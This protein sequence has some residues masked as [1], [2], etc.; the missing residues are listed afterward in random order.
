MGV[1]SSGML[2]LPVHAI[3]AGL[4]FFL[5]FAAIKQ[6]ARLFLGGFWIFILCFNSLERAFVCRPRYL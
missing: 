5:E 1:I 3:V 4:F 6:H 2:A